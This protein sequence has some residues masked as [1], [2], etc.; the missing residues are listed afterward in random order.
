MTLRE[1]TQALANHDDVRWGKH[2]GK[3]MNAYHFGKRSVY[4]EQKPN[5]F[6]L[7]RKLRHFA[8]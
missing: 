1:L 3:S 8:G 5:R 7:G 4:I 6:D 2:T